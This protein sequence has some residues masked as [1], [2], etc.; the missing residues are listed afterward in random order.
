MLAARPRRTEKELQNE[1]VSER[2]LVAFV[3]DVDWVEI[4]GSAGP[5][6]EATAPSDESRDE[7]GGVG[8]VL[9][10]LLAEV[11]PPQSYEVKTVPP[12]GTDSSVM[13]V[14]FDGR[15]PVKIKMTL[16]E[17]WM[18]V[19]MEQGATYAFEP[20]ENAIMKMPFGQGT[21]AAS[22]PT[23]YVD[24]DASVRG[25]ETVDGV[26]CWVIDSAGPAQSTVWVGTK[27]GLPYQMETEEG[28]TKFVYSRINEVQD[29]EFEL[30]QGIPVMDLAKM[31]QGG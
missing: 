7:A 6:E 17:G 2:A 26:R 5:V 4:F 15:E 10:A 27:D 25:K 30:P 20:S 3:R 16:A 13:L 24:Y 8:D 31:M 11:D 1:E 12:S 19:D 22:S 23:D 9:N 28:V 21:A 29:G 14:K 18:I